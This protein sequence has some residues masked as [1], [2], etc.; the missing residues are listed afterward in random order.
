MLPGQNYLSQHCVDITLDNKVAYIYCNLTEGIFVSE[1]KLPLIQIIP[2]T[3][4]RGIEDIHIEYK[5]PLMLD[6][7]RDYIT[8]ISIVLYNEVGSKLK[9]DKHLP[10]QIKLLL[11]EK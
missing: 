5:V 1:D 10:A 11:I 4:S 3:Q 6:L 7:N 8:H 9:F 2:L